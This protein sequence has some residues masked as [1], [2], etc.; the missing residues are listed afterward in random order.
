MKLKQVPHVLL[1]EDVIQTLS[2][3]YVIYVKEFIAHEPT[4]LKQKCPQ[5]S[6]DEVITLRAFIIQNY[7]PPVN[8]IEAKHETILTDLFELNTNHIYEIYG[9]PGSGKSQ[10]CLTLTAMLSEQGKVFYIDTKNDFSSSRL[11]C[12]LKNPTNCFNNIKVAKAFD[13]EEVLKVTYELLANS[14]K[15]SNSKLLI[16]DNIASIV[17]P[18]FEE[19]N[20]SELFAAIGQLISNLRKIAFFYQMTIV[21]VNNTTNNENRPALGKYFANV[22]N[23]RLFIQ[24]CHQIV[25]EKSLN[26]SIRD[27]KVP[28]VID[29]NGMNRIN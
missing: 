29:E 5:L 2:N 16:L 26:V 7:G 9:P 21:I 15:M 20:S 25:I 11:K 3:N 18:L 28:V 19:E 17:W 13:I 27:S 8:Q 1:T 4:L 12:I 6:Y 24:N 22:A 14:N 10:F 23:T